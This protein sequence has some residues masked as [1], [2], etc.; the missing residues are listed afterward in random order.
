MSASSTFRTSKGWKKSLYWTPRR[1]CP[2]H[3]VHTQYRCGFRGL[4]VPC[5]MVPQSILLVDWQVNT[6]GHLRAQQT[7]TRDK[8]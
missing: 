4:S 8:D 7:C 1:S 5:I 2:C 6:D 3:A